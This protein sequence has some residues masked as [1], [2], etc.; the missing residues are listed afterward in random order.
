MKTLI[1]VVLLMG[2]ISCGAPKSEREQVAPNKEKRITSPQVE[3][4][5]DTINGLLARNEE[6]KTTTLKVIKLLD[7]LN[8]ENVVYAINK[9]LL[10]KLSEGLSYKSLVR[11]TT[12]RL[13]LCSYIA[14]KQI[15]IAA[16][17]E[18]YSL[19]EYKRDLES[20]ITDEREI[21]KGVNYQENVVQAKWQAK[22][23]TWAQF[24][25][26]SS[27]Y[28]AKL[29][30]KNVILNYEFNAGQLERLNV[31]DPSI[32]FYQNPVLQV[33]RSLNPN[34]KMTVLTLNTVASFDDLAG[35]D[36]TEVS[37]RDLR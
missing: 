36:L 17:P 24:N 20:T 11:V 25:N 21:C 1:A 4:L 6:T 5:Q 12:S 16:L 35:V 13:D 23:N 14:K 2:L 29:D 10:S 37:V 33:D 18:A 28:L 15:T 7:Q 9:N 26:R 22:N 34:M 27:F 19:R 3:D 30:G 8:Y 32:T 31:Y